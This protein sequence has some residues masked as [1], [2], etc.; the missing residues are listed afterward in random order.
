MARTIKEDAPV[1]QRNSRLKAMEAIAKRSS[2]FRPA[3][4]VLTRVRAVPTIFPGYDFA[5]RVGGHPIER[6]ATVHGPSNHGKTAFILGL[7][8]SFLMRDHFFLHIDAEM[9]TPIDWLRNLM[10]DIAHHPGFLA[11]RP[12][13]YEE[14]VDEVRDFLTMMEKEKAAG[15]L[16]PQTSAILAVDSIRKLI[17]KKFFEKVKQGSEKSGVDG[18]GG[19]GAQIKAALNAAWLDELV[20]LL[21]HTGTSAVLIARESEDVEADANDKKWGNDFKVTGGKAIIYDSS[22]V[23][24]IERSGMIYGPGPENEK[25]PVYGEKCV[26]SIRKTKIAG[27]ND[28]TPKFYF[29]LSNGVH[30]P[31]GFDRARD[32]LDLAKKFEVVKA[33]GSWISFGKKRWQGENSA[34]KALTADKSTLAAIEEQVREHFEN[35]EPEAEDDE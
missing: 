4:E 13:S 9:T 27:K 2:G 20:P 34:V 5:T 11:R 25:K 22:L 6:V 1:S 19:R 14:T 32:V 35:N 30:I 3:S 21:Y 12:K 8:M 16:D 17:P 24:R 33:S 23:I 10:G 28:K 7:G 18:M 29:H 15:N 31:E 26:G